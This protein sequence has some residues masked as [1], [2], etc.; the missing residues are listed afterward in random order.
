[1][2]KTIDSRREVAILPT[3]E[4]A[5]AYAA[6]DFITHGNA[7]IDDKGS[8]TVALSGGSTPKA[9]FHLLSSP[10]WRTKIDWSQIHLYWSDERCVPPQDPESNYKM[11]MDAG[12]S[13]LP[14]HPENIHR[15][16]GERP[17][18][19]AAAEY[20]QLIKKLDSPLDFVMLGMG[21]DGHTASLFPNTKGLSEEKH[22]VVA[23]F[24]PQKNSW[25][26]SFTFPTINAANH[27][28]FYALGE[29]KAQ[30]LAQVLEPDAAPSVPSIL[31]GTPNNK[32]LWIIDK[33]AAS[34]L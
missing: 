10:E 32:A 27:I 12:F 11:A 34:L 8:F 26:L 18:V 17:P 29:G 22:P 31:V 19:E 20:S 2:I 1:M 25:R 3:A 13:T 4:T 23:N 9:L 33:K 21:P 5:V 28:V 7:A 15:M 30:M 6:E 16:K 14:F 24:V